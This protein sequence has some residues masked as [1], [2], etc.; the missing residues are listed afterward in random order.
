[1]AM[2]P[3]VESKDYLKQTNA[4]KDRKTKVSHEKKPPRDT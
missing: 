1:M 4:E 2:N 3:M